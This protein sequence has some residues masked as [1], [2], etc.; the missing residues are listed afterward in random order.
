MTTVDNSY[1]KEIAAVY[2]DRGD[3]H[4][5]ERPAGTNYQLQIR[6]V[7]DEMGR[8]LKEV[9]GG[10]L[11][12]RTR[13]GG[14]DYS[15]SGKNADDLALA[16]LPYVVKAKDLLQLVCE[17]R[18]E[19][20][21]MGHKLSPQHRLLRV[22]VAKEVQKARARLWKVRGKQLSDALKKYAEEE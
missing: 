1:I 8:F 5:Y 3:I 12:N 10:R 17:A 19:W 7:S 16:V 15:C 13:T 20:N 14:F 11:H 18:K 6:A 4:W 9:W 21:T 22:E 2:D